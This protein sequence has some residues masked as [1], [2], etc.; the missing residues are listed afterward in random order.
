MKLTYQ[1][2]LPDVT[3]LGAEVGDGRADANIG[4]DPYFGTCS[5]PLCARR[6]FIQFT[7]H[8]I[9]QC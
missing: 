4:G 1:H 2:T 8:W 5:V 3:D 9:D 7:G 6:R